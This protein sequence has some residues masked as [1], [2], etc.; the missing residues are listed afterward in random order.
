MWRRGSASALQ[1]EGRGFKSRHLQG[2]GNQDFL[3]I[4]SKS[5]Y[6]AL[7]KYKLVWL[8]CFSSDKGKRTKQ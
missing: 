4:I 7:E 6:F 5:I 2:K 3:L 8:K 1:A